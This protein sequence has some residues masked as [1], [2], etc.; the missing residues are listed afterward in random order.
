MGRLRSNK[1][2]NRSRK[3]QRSSNPMSH[4]LSVLLISRNEVY[5]FNMGHARREE[6]DKAKPQKLC[7]RQG[8]EKRHLGVFES[9]E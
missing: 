7:A 4:L 1:E 6:I 2:R 5:R 8:C 3:S 9:H